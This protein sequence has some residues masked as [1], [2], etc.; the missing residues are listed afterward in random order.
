M[1]K[2]KCKKE[3]WQEVLTMLNPRLLEKWAIERIKT[4]DVPTALML[5]SLAE[6]GLKILKCT[7]KSKAEITVSL[8]FKDAHEMIQ[9]LLGVSRSEYIKVNAQAMQDKLNKEIVNY[10]PIYQ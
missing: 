6:V 8:S 4:K 7:L 10:K 2:F 5:L 9:F 3:F 1:I